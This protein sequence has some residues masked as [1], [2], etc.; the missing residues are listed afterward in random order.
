MTT[1]SAIATA[2]SGGL[3]GRPPVAVPDRDGVFVVGDW[4]GPTGH[5]ADAVLASARTAADAAI[6]HLSTRR[7]VR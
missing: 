2:A 6:A 3:A 7:R 5:L 4:V 1:V